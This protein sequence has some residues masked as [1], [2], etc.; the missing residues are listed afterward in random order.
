[1]TGNANGDEVD[2]R[3]RRER[4]ESAQG[5]VRGSAEE[6]GRGGGGERRGVSMEDDG[7][8]VLVGLRRWTW[9]MG[10]GRCAC[11]C[12]NAD[13]E[14]GGLSGREEKMTRVVI[15]SYAS[16]WTPKHSYTKSSISNCNNE[17][18]M[19]HSPK[20]KRKERSADFDDEAFALALRAAN[21][22]LAG[23]WF[24]RAFSARTLSGIHIERTSMRYHGSEKANE[25][26]EIH[27]ALRSPQNRHAATPS[28]D[29]L[30]SLYKNPQTGR[31]NYTWI[32]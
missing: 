11:V 5:V 15:P 10:R 21:R 28:S 13:E 16:S 2:M 3:S 32:S 23:N 30:L 24:R 22:E 27:P 9:G 6:R 18:R 1:M 8:V 20:M 12:G 26:R 29:D 4:N 17:K 7:V 19:D 14:Q 31:K 25:D